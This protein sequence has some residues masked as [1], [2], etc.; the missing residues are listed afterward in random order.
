M[1]VNKWVSAQDKAFYAIQN[2]LEEIGCYL[3][4]EMLD[5]AS[6]LAQAAVDHPSSN[7]SFAEMTTVGETVIIK[8]IKDCA[9]CGGN[10]ANLVARRV[11]A[12]PYV[13]DGKDAWY[14]T[15]CPT[16]EEPIFVSV[17]HLELP[18]EP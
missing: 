18:I 10:H 8:E 6:R 9:R 2:A 1:K 16:L 4:D 3:T 11:A 7:V 12:R 5:T 14:W 15:T 17:V 13:V